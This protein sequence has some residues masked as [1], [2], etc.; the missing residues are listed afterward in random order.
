MAQ[1]TTSTEPAVIIDDT[2][3]R[4][5]HFDVPDEALNDLRR[6]IEATRW[7]ERET[8]PDQSR[9]VP[10]ATMQELARYWAAEYDWRP[11]EEKL[12]ALL[13]FVTEIDGLDTR[14]Q[15]APLIAG[16]GGVPGERRAR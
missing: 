1:E 12:K 9:A 2:S 6:R 16:R 7:P 5:F 10:L 8:V 11:G 13:H 15:I 4:P 14:V 3:I